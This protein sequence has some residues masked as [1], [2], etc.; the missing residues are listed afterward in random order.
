MGTQEKQ[1]EKYSTKKWM[2]FRVLNKD[3]EKRETGSQS[4]TELHT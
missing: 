2:C 4:C 1:F 3:E